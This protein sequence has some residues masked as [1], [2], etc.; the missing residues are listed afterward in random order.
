MGRGATGETVCGHRRARDIRSDSGSMSRRARRARSDAGSMSLEVVL[1]VPVLMLLALFV[2]WAGRG[3]RAALITDLAAEEAATA[4]ALSCEK[5]EDDACQDLVGD[6]LSAKPGLDFLCIGGAQLDGGRELVEIKRI[7]FAPVSDPV[8]PTEAKG[9]DLFGVR[10]LCETD[11]AV[12]PLQ[13]LFPTVSFRGQASEVSIQQG[14]PRATLSDATADE[15]DIL[16]FKLELDAPI[17]VDATITYSFSD[18]LDSPDY[19]IPGDCNASPPPDYKWP[20]PLEVRMTEGEARKTITVRTCVD[21]LHEADERFELRLIVPHEVPGDDTTP[22]VFVID[23]GTTPC[24]AIAGD[25]TSSDDCAVGTIEDDDPKLAVTVTGGTVAEDSGAALEF[26]VEIDRPIG[27][28]VTVQYQTA[29][30]DPLRPGYAQHGQ[31]PPCPSP[32]NT[33]TVPVDYIPINSGSLTFR[34]DPGGLTP[35]V[36]PVEIE[37]CDDLVGEPDET[38]EL[39]WWATPSSTPSGQ[40]F[41]TIVDNE[42]RLVV[43]DASGCESPNPELPIPDGCGDGNLGAEEVVFTVRRVDDSGVHPE[44]TFHYV[45][46]PNPNIPPLGP[47]A[48]HGFPSVTNPGVTDPCNSDQPLANVRQPPDYYDYEPVSSLV[49]DPGPV[50]IPAGAANSE[51][52]IPVTLNNDDLNEDPET[53]RLRLCNSSDNAHVDRPEGEGTIEDDDPSP[54]LTVRDA[55]ACES[56][57]LTLCPSI[58]GLG[59]GELVFMASLSTPSGREVHLD[60]CYVPADT[61]PPGEPALA[62]VD[63]DAEPC[64][65]PTRQRVTFPVASRPPSPTDPA[66]RQ[67][68]RVPVRDDLL[69]EGL[70][71]E[72]NAETLALRFVPY[73]ATVDTPGACVAWDDPGGTGS[74]TD[75]C[76]LG[77][78]IDND[79]PPAASIFGPVDSSGLPVAVCESADPDDLADPD[80][81]GD[82]GQIVFDVYLVDPDNP[83]VHPLVDPDT[84]RPSGVEVTVKY[85]MVASNTALVFEPDLTASMDDLVPPGGADPWAGEVTFDPGEYHKTVTVTLV[86]D[87][88]DEIDPED[89]ELR[90]A[91]TT[92][93]VNA[94]KGVDGIGLIADDDDPPELRVMDECFEDLN[95]APED[96]WPRKV[97]QDGQACAHEALGPV[98]F[99][100]GLFDPD[101]PGTLIGSGREVSVLWQTMPS[102]LA[103]A[104]EQATGGADYV[105]VDASTDYGDRRVV[106]LVGQKTGTFRVQVNDDDLDEK[107]ELF[108]VE[109]LEDTGD[110]SDPGDTGNPGVVRFGAWFGQGVIV[111]DDEV[112]LSFV[113]NC[114]TRHVEGVVDGALQDVDVA[115]CGDEDPDGSS[116]T[117]KV[118]VEPQTSQPVTVHYFTVD[119]A[120]WDQRAAA[121]GRD[122]TEQAENPPEQRQTLV[123]PANTEFGTIDVPILDDGVYEH[124][125]VFQLRLADPINAV[126]DGPSAL[127]AIFDD[128]APPSLRVGDAIGGEGSPVVFT[129]ELVHPDSGDRAEIE[130]EVRAPWHTV[131]GT[132]ESG[133]DGDYLAGTGTIEFDPSNPVVASR[134]EQTVSVFTIASDDVAEPAETFELRVGPGPVIPAEIVPDQ[135]DDPCVAEAD[136]GTAEDDCAVGTI[137]DESEPLVRVFNAIATEGGHLEFIVRLVDAD[138]PNQMLVSAEAVTVHFATATAT[139]ANPAKDRP[140]G[141]DCA[142]QVPEF[143]EVYDYDFDYVAL[144]G[145]VTFDPEDS[146]VRARTEQR[147]TVATCDDYHDE[148]DT[149]TLTLE[150]TA[151]VGAQLAPATAAT[152]WIRDNDDRPAATI[153]DTTPDDPGN[154]AFA[155]EGT[156]VVFTVRL[157]NQAD[158]SVPAPS[159]RSIEV[160]YHTN[161][162]GMGALNAT[163]GTSEGVPSEAD[164]L[165]VLADSKNPTTAQFGAGQT[166]QQVSI[167]TYP[168]DRIE[169]FERFQLF[170]DLPPLANQDDFVRDDFVGIGAIVDGCIDP[171]KH[172]DGDPVPTISV[173]DVTAGERGRAEIHISLNACLTVDVDVSLIQL[174]NDEQTATEPDDYAFT[175]T[176]VTIPAEALTPADAP[177]ATIEP[178]LI[179]ESDEWFE[180]AADWA[181]TVPADYQT[182]DVVATVTIVDDDDPPVAVVYGPDPVTAGETL[183]FRVRLVH[184]L[185]NSPSANSVQSGKDVSVDVY[186]CCGNA[187]AGTDYDAI[188]QDPPTTYEFPAGVVTEHTVEVQT[189]E[190]VVLGTSPVHPDDVRRHF[191][192]RLDNPVNADLGDNRT[193]RGE[194]LRPCVAGDDINRVPRIRL[195]DD[196]DD[197]AA[198]DDAPWFNYVPARTNEPYAI[199]R[200]FGYPVR[201]VQGPVLETAGELR[202]ELRFDPPICPGTDIHLAYDVFSLLY[203]SNERWGTAVRYVNSYRDPADYAIGSGS[204][205][206]TVDEDGNPVN[207]NG[208]PLALRVEV[209]DDVLDEKLIEWFRVGIRWGDDMIAS[210]RGGGVERP[211][212]IGLIV[213]DDPLVVTLADGESSEGGA[214]D[215]HVTSPPAERVVSLDYE[216]VQRRLG[217]DIAES[218][219]SCVAGS[220]IDFERADDSLRFE[221]VRAFF[222]DIL[223]LY[224]PFSGHDRL[225]HYDVRVQTC[226]DDVPEDDETFLL[227]VAL[228][229]ADSWDWGG[230]VDEVYLE[231]ARAVGTI[232]ECIDASLPPSTEFPPTLITE[233][234]TVVE[235]QPVVVPFTLSPSPFCDQK[236]LRF[237]T[238]HSTDELL[239]EYGP[240][241]DFTGGEGGRASGRWVWPAFTRGGSIGYQTRLEDPNEL[242]PNESF[243]VRLDFCRSSGDRPCADGNPER[244]FHPGYADLP[245]AVS[246]VTIRDEGCFNAATNPNDPVGLTPVAGVWFEDEDDG[247]VE[248]LWR[249]GFPLCEEAFVAYDTQDITAERSVDFNAP[250]VVGVLV[251]AGETEVRVDVDLIDDDLAEGVESFRQRMRWHGG[252]PDEWV[253]ASDRS[254]LWSNV[255]HRII[256]DDCLSLEPESLD[257]DDRVVSRVLES[258]GAED[259]AWGRLAFV[260]EGETARARLTLDP[261]ICEPVEVV[262]QIVHTESDGEDFAQWHD[263]P[264]S[265]PYW[266]GAE[267]WTRTLAEGQAESLSYFAIFDDGVEEFDERYRVKVGW[268]DWA[269]PLCEER[270]RFCEPA[271]ATVHTIRGSCITA[272]ERNAVGPDPVTLTIHDVDEVREISFGY[273]VTLR[274]DRVYCDQAHVELRAVISPGDTASSA[275]VNTT[276]TRILQLG[277]GQGEVRLT[278]QN[279]RDAAASIVWDQ[280][281]EGNE[282]FTMQARVMWDGARSDRQWSEATVTIVDEDG[283]PA[284][285]VSDAGR[286]AEG[287]TMVFT[288]SLV[289]GLGGEPRPSGKEVRARYRFGGTAARGVSC[290]QDGVDYVGPS[291]RLLVF[292]PGE[293]DKQVELEICDDSVLEPPE[294]V[295]LFLSSGT[296]LNA[297]IVDGGGFGLIEGRPTITISDLT[298]WEFVNRERLFG[299]VGNQAVRLDDL[300]EDVTV[301]WA[302]EDCAA[303]DPLCPDP[304]TAGLDYDADEGTMTFEFR[305]YILGAQTQWIAP[306]I[307]EDTEFEGHEEQFFVRLSNPSGDVGLAGA[308]HPSEPVG[309]V[310]IQDFDFGACVRFESLG[311]S[312]EEGHTTTVYLVL[313]REVSNNVEVD[314]E[315]VQKSGGNSALEGLDYVAGSDTVRFAPN[316]TRASLTVATLA[317]TVDEG[318]EF[319]GVR[320]SN[321]VGAGVCTNFIAGTDIVSGYEA[322]V[323]IEDVRVPNTDGTGLPTI[324]GYRWVGATLTAHTGEMADEDGMENAV[325]RFQWL[326]SDGEDY[327]D[328]PGARRRSYELVDADE[329]LHMRVRASYTDDR[330]HPEAR[331][332][333]PYGPI[334]PP[335]PPLTA[336][337]ELVPATH[338]GTNFTFEVHFSEEFPLS[339]GSVR[340]AFT[341]QRGTLVR[342]SRVGSGSQRWEIEIDPED[343]Y[344]VVVTLP[345][346]SSCDASGAIC[347]PDGR[348]LSIGDTATVEGPP[349]PPLTAWFH[350]VPDKHR[351]TSYVQDGVVRQGTFIFEMRFSEEPVLGEYFHENRPGVISVQGGSL[352]HSRH[353]YIITGWTHIGGIR[354]PLGYWSNHWKLWIDPDSDEAVTVTLP[355]ADDCA[356]RLAVCTSDG[357]PLSNTT[358]VVIPGP[359]DDEE[360]EEEEGFTAS[361]VGAPKEHDGSRQFSFTLR[362]D[363]ESDESAEIVLADATALSDAFSVTGASL[364]AARVNAT[365]DALWQIDVTPQTAGTIRILLPPTTDC[366]AAGAVCA[367]D[368][369]MLLNLSDATVRAPLTAR[370][371]N[372]PET[373]G[374]RSDGTEDPNIAF[375]VEF[376]DDLGDVTELDNY[377]SYGTFKR[378][379]VVNGAQREGSHNVWAN[380]VEGSKRRYRI[381]MQAPAR[382]GDTTIVLLPETDCDTHAYAIELEDKIRHDTELEYGLCTPDGRKLSNTATAT[383]GA[384]V[385]RASFSG[386][387]EHHIWQ[388]D[389]GFRFDLTFNAELQINTATI[390]RALSVEGGTLKWLVNLYN[391]GTRRYYRMWIIP[392][393]RTVTVTLPATTDCEA[394]RAIC[395]G[396]L[397]LANTATATIVEALKSYFVGVPGHHGG[398]G[399]SFDFE[400]QFNEELTLD[401]A[402]VEGALE[403]TGATATAERVVAASTK[404]WTITVTPTAPRVTITLPR[405]RNCTAP[406]AICADDGRKL[407][408]QRTA[409]VRPRLT[410]EITNMPQ[411][412]AGRPDVIHI[413]AGIVFNMTFSD[414]IEWD[415]ITI[416]TDAFTVTGGTLTYATEQHNSSRYWKMTVIPNGDDDV[417]ITLPATTDCTAT[418]AICTSDGRKLSNSYSTTVEGGGLLTAEFVEMPVYHRGA[419]FDFK[420]QFSDNVDAG[421]SDIADDALTVTGATVTAARDDDDSNQNW[422]ITVTPDAADED[423]IILLPATTDCDADGAICTSDGH[424][425]SAPTSAT[426]DGRSRL[427]AQFVGM[428]ASH[429]GTSFQ[430]ELQFSE[431]IA[432]ISSGY[433]LFAIKVENGIVGTMIGTSPR[434]TVAVQPDRSGK[435]VELRLP[436]TTECTFLTSFCTADGAML[437]NSLSA[438]VL[439][440]HLTAEFTVPDNH[441]GSAFTIQLAFSETILLTDTI[442]N[443]FHD[444]RLIVDG[445]TVTVTRDDDTYKNFTIT[446]TPDNST[447]PVSIQLTPETDCTSLQSVCTAEGKP[448]TN[449]PTA[450]IGGS[451]S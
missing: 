73:Y 383:V 275:D 270:N 325:F 234:V 128:E 359:D 17:A 200:G 428:P 214:V 131:D 302:T 246:T 252:V 208:N 411:S 238:D 62:G 287:D 237:Q 253:H 366:E 426:V 140:E 45:T 441:T 424:K 75:D 89:F 342:A 356:E 153:V 370:F 190:R 201:G 142:V 122:Y 369:R 95:D 230:Y 145:T 380:L 6:V 311:Y 43:D 290:D 397:M 277:A 286:V 67:D 55:D 260:A 130:R 365:S 23:A 374:L 11:G 338:D 101:N 39:Q 434:W 26:S 143:G 72:D 335:P 174:A 9:V 81:C 400:L 257:I 315:T 399:Q 333:E 70:N 227:R 442:D 403:V 8:N 150:M 198:L 197:G 378:K 233:D 79:L 228:N 349:E 194:S 199:L 255:I 221:Y 243:Q 297:R 27:R 319:F 229:V 205:R 96:R 118:K 195:V 419:E 162:T 427:T 289:F 240:G 264:L 447:G 80:D 382:S 217:D 215:F 440:G 350:G 421:P 176:T 390:R 25:G 327:V 295:L 100:V 24:A 168:D 326:R 50:T 49:S 38:V 269:G 149:E 126:L 111:D 163:P 65:P 160:P 232:I 99:K 348:P 213:D 423:V 305:P 250:H 448:L 304:A 341:V 209:H 42:P 415:H 156:P 226:A 323:R 83:G 284:L 309:V 137:V 196:P 372:M 401:R 332:S 435:P 362:F 110:P 294:R 69:D 59:A 367:S 165:Q 51:V 103:P 178:D 352:R 192:V 141:E 446:V 336:R 54:A 268:G 82:G 179:D 1:V 328:I 97:A 169:I 220:T 44:V 398:E 396:G 129:A 407:I 13:G 10:F 368:A 259:A 410:V 166:Q 113:D 409:T 58:P 405:T 139:G 236:Q 283:D 344:T 316:Q 436:A 125:E 121:A 306:S 449:N 173:D 263:T 392:T 450:T 391:D 107:N 98:E 301:D 12:A 334:G 87:N 346:T 251:P 224:T 218:G 314:W 77:R 106:I 443:V 32:P 117:F 170:L 373:R 354:V 183:A 420:L 386:V 312:V 262:Q 204:I 438:T 416:W 74:K 41:G 279:R 108:R 355:E 317:D 451:G 7:P 203:D 157:V 300:A 167:E 184:P 28:D 439:F 276:V 389:P 78:I 16:E 60:Y 15:G 353:Q 186:T 46:L 293:T 381:V 272:E 148:P 266:E 235:G 177:T 379:F 152:G 210:W 36:P 363:K 188:A 91:D 154:D 132:A 109:V 223:W 31:A 393:S 347:A 261:P 175:D 21:D 222:S 48:T 384:P 30:Y 248:V 47:D 182:D 385:L 116:V 124:D 249:L 84:V 425:L 422:T 340:R 247:D 285:S 281:A 329:G 40:A 158:R 408:T 288:V 88:L 241:K 313:D 254:L 345:A 330:D 71:D 123:I 52:Q 120:S 296:V 189:H 212:F 29:R 68:I 225:F 144:S 35:T 181:S 432:D 202:F 271:A 371:V 274:T 102:G 331:T 402:A 414:R 90:P 273:L 239:A 127:G 303:T 53:F 394:D 388:S 92:E 57:D 151:A 104:D 185:R 5:G 159:A 115:A 216:T 258:R 377:S 404:N 66:L 171:S 412:H 298:V 20:A 37:V 437:S 14:P 343:N 387:P 299:V 18:D 417:T 357:R 307:V 136:G 375:E 339:W 133:T 406:H 395:S 3:G 61:V 161:S 321:P 155:L 292:A 85:R 413:D 2:L 76:A 291:D 180:V 193:A 278:V 280:I 418:G 138:N 4:A 324:S 430:F 94:V 19:T 207:S 337:F 376:S 64:P 364:T 351:G 318:P 244:R 135:G 146:N 245:A 282:T 206:G 267:A 114:T 320:L 134:T 22:P 360:E 56:A 231:D 119:L 86:D 433:L 429:D 310:R 242:E 431:D 361:F 172:Q 445:A 63:F 444:E 308:S 112:E 105:T 164:Y 211:S 191:L 256:D 33:N 93:L 147:V 34:P 187:E 358:T 265:R 322:S 219:L